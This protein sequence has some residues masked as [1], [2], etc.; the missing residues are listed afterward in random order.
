MDIRTYLTREAAAL[1]DASLR[2]LPSATAWPAERARR[3]ALYLD[4]MGLASHLAAPRTPL[5]VQ[6]TG[7]LRREGY[8]VEKLCFESLPRLYVTGNLYVPEGLSAPAPAVL[9]LCGHS[10]T[11]KIHYQSH[12]RRWAQLGFV[13]LVVDTIQYGEIRGDHHGVYSQGR[14]H[15]ISRGY[16]PGAVECWNGIRA[17][18]LLAAR[19]EVDGERMGVT[20]ISGGGA[21]SWWLAAADDRVK[22]VA[23]VCA[24]GTLR[25]H[26][27]D[28]TLDGHCDCMF[29]L[30]PD[31]WDLADV[32]ALIAPRPLLIASANRDGLYTIESIRETYEKL[33]R[34]YTHLG[35]EDRIELVETPG[36]HSY[37]ESS[38]TRIF[39]LFLRELAGRNIAPEDVGDLDVTQ[40]EVDGTV[41]RVFYPGTDVTI[42]AD[43]RTTVIDDV[44][45]PVAYPAVV[46]GRAQLERRRAAVVDGLRETAFQRFPAVDAPLDLEIHQR[47]ETDIASNLRFRFT[48]EPGWRLSGTYSRRLDWDADQGVVVNLRRPGE[49][50]WA[51]ADASRDFLGRIGERYGVAQVETRGCGE[52]GWAPELD[53]HVRR[54]AAILGRTVASMQVYDTLRALQAVRQLEGVDP[55]RVLLAGRDQMTVIALCA[56]LLDGRV[57]GVVIADPPATLNR[58]SRPDGRGSAIELL[59]ALRITDLPEIAALLWPAALIF[60]GWRP[61]AYRLAEET[62]RNLGAPGVVRHLK[63]LDDLV[64][65][66]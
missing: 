62:Y 48:G 50:R 34:L 24:T 40:E 42:P 9:Y 28:R 16:N 26:I 35:A 10:G 14:F 43:E 8:S 66:P 59:H 11:Q 38:R 12:P 20:G 6:V 13:A 45:V 61:E 21:I 7:T 65:L 49:D 25:S 17:L 32:G 4:R 46:T 23:P 31:G 37:H 56:A 51:Y 39:S 44:F 3:R 47:Y 22:V 52:A 54:A 64:A 5:N 18:D 33:Q 41:L 57:S 2:D 27:A 1:T 53:W 58:A 36:R 60:V 55:D 63:H 29:H 30:N 19:P 15:W